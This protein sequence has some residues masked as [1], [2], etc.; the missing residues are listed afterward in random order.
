MSFR[1][2]HDGFIVSQFLGGY[3]H[4]FTYLVS[5]NSTGRSLLVDAAVPVK[6]ILDHCAAKPEALLITHSHGDHIAYINEYL[7]SFPGLKII[8]GANTAIS[9]EYNIIKMI[10][11]DI[12]PLGKLAFKIIET[13]GHLSDSICFHLNNILFTG[14]TLFV[15]RTGRTVNSGSNIADLYNSVYNKILLL[16]KKTMIYPGHNYGEAP[17]ISLE[18]NIKLSPLLNA[19]NV[20][21][22]ISRM[23]KFE[24]ERKNIF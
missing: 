20:D 22:F 24:T 10:E 1:Y 13:P 18:E 16:D 17:Y 2:N 15:G 3:D 14:D 6:T 19:L 9:D 21:D 23:D 7:A 11:N 4:N 12:Y 8:A 5:E